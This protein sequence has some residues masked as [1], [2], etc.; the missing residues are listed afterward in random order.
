[1]TTAIIFTSFIVILL[2]YF[3]VARKTRKDVIHSPDQYFLSKDYYEN[4]D[5]SSVQT[6]YFL[7]MATIYPFIF[8]AFFGMT[9]LA[10]WNILFYAIGI[11]FLIIVIP[12]FKKRHNSIIGSTKT[13]H[14]YI[15]LIH[16]EPDLRKITAWA[17]LVGFVGLAVFEIVWGS[18]VLKI[19][20]NGN[21]NVY[22]FT[23]AL[24]AIYL[25]I[26]LRIGGQRA[27]FNT[28]IIQIVIAYLGL[29]AFVS[30]CIHNPLVDITLDQTLH[31]T[32]QFVIFLCI[33]MFALRIKKVFY[34]KRKSWFLNLL[35]LISLGI[36][37]VTTFNKEGFFSVVYIH[38]FNNSV[39]DIV[40]QR[41]N[42][43]ALIAF[44]VLPIFLQFV[45]MTNWQRMVAVKD[46]EDHLKS[47]KIR[48]GLLQFILESPLS[49][50]LPV[51][52][53]LSS[54]QIL[55]PEFDGDP[56]NEILISL[57]TSNETISVIVSVLVVAGIISIFMSTADGLMMAVGYSYSYDLNRKS[58]RF[59]DEESRKAITW[60]MSPDKVNYVLNRGR[61]AISYSLIV[62]VSLFI[63]L[64]IFFEKGEEV[65]GI[66]LAF[67]APMISF[68]PS[69]LIPTL[70]GRRASGFTSKLS[71]ILAA[72][73]GII[74]GI[75]S[76]Y[77]GGIWLWIPIIGAAAISWF[78]Y[79]FGFVVKSVKLPN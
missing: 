48:K 13:L 11:L 27:T 15:A 70:T 31:L 29:H 38:N 54:I 35:V 76:I 1:M 47:N 10:I 28:S 37:I 26:Y 61:N 67:F 51:V 42:V 58:R 22:Y 32:L 44:A 78:I 16:K 62:V 19:L 71:I 63:L 17:S 50:L 64:D 33:I 55:N 8:F 3:I 2:I 39:R 46:G 30:W 65:L 41:E 18:K 66:F 4:D 52:I 45:D 43:L 9:W 34:I 57:F 68:A 12:Y 7:Q 5:Y 40:S 14:A 69:I 77:L 75:I 25:I 53:G 60:S 6:G 36:L 24:M 72:I 20:F 74:A 23:I 79:L 59:I 49:W 56:W 21:D 73:F